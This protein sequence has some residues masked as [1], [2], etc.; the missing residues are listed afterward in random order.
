M[1]VDEMDNMW[2]FFPHQAVFS[3]Y[4]KKIAFDKRTRQH[5]TTMARLVRPTAGVARRDCNKRM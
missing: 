5:S 3:V 2:E 4:D 1:S